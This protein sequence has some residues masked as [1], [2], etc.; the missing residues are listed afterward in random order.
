MIFGNRFVR[1]VCLGSAGAWRLFFRQIHVSRLNEYDHD[2]FHPENIARAR[3][4]V[5]IKMWL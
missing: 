5:V 4:R 1:G 3:A 2:L